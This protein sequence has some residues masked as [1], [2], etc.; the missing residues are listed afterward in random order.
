M[1]TDSKTGYLILNTG[2]PDEPSI[3]ALRKYLKEFLSDP[4]MLDFPSTRPTEL[5]KGFD[6]V[7]NKFATIFRWIILNLIVLPFR[8]QRYKTNTKVFGLKK[9]HHYL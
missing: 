9:V 8:P 3:P 2:T 7:K 6:V 5:S 4:D 1:V